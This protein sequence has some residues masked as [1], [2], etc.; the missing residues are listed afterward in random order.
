MATTQGGC[1]RRQQYITDSQRPLRLQPRCLE[2]DSQL[3]YRSLSTTANPWTLQTLGGSEETKKNLS[4]AKIYTWRTGNFD[5]SSRRQDEV[6]NSAKSEAF[7][8]VFVFYW[9]VSPRHRRLD[10]FCI[11][12]I[13]LT[14]EYSFIY[15]F[16]NVACCT[17]MKMAFL[18]L[19]PLVNIWNKR[20]K[21]K[22]K[23][24]SSA[25][26]I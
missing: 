9:T 26:P 11:L 18:V 20:K 1:S 10:S 12:R 19:F 6:S 17:N 25:V 4:R 21:R 14:P 15:F 23:L 8:G 13:S 5:Q 3:I 7:T 2:S 24:E 16:G 22:E